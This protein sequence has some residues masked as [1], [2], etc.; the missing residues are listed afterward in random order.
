MALNGAPPPRYFF[1]IGAMKAGTT[2]LFKYLA[3]HP[4]LCP[5][6]RKEPRVFRDPGD[7]TAQLRTLQELFAKRTDEPWCFEASTAYTKYPRFPGVPARLRAALPDARFI[8]MVRNPVER[9]WSHYVHNL[10][11]GREGEIFARAMKRKHQYLDFSRYHLQ[12]QQYHSAFPK[13]RVLVQVFEEM[14]ID[15]AA[16]VRS[17]C[18]FLGID[19]SYCPPTREVAYNASSEKR[20]ASRPL[21]ALQRLGLDERLPWR[22]RQHL[23]TAGAPLPRK[24]EALTPALR[25]T[26]ADALR[27][28]TE[29]FLGSFGRRIRAW[30]DFA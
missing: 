16:T 22:L 7:P 14:A 25:A 15:P 2:S 4:E 26:I 18:E 19:A 20:T 30:S 29:A 5:S 28:D 9:T 21:R 23:R 12:L 6:I 24:A 13:D 17:I 8:Y 11:H 1:I 27:V 10:A 3:D